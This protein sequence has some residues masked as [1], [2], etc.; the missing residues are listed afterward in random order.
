MRTVKKVLEVM[1]EK[2]SKT[3]G[4]KMLNLMNKISNFKTDENVDKLIDRFE[5][6]VTETDKLKLATNLRYALSLQFVERLE[7]DGKINSGEK[8]R[9]RDVIEDYAGEPRVGDVT[10]YL[11]KE[12]R[13]IKVI[14]NREEPFSGKD[15]KTLYVRNNDNHSR[16]NNWKNSRESK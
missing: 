13:K 5:E 15:Y 9:L 7:K 4:E 14:E 16:F 12:L 8:L 11:K 3:T 6:M 10:Q 1:S 2:F